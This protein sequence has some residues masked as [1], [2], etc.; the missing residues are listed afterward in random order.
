[1]T[2]KWSSCAPL[3][4]EVAPVGATSPGT[5]VYAIGDMH[6]CWALLDAIHEG[7]LFDARLRRAARRKVI[8]LGDYVSRGPDSRQVVE[9]LIEWRPPG[10]EIVALKGNHEDLLLRFLDGDFANGAQWLDHG[11]VE[12][13]AHYG[14]FLEDPAA[15]D[16][17][18][19]ADARHR[20]LATVPAAH[21]AFLR[22]LATSHRDGDY[23]FA[24]AGVLPGVPV[25][26]Q[27][28]SNLMWIR[29]RF[30]ESAADHGAIVVHG[31]SISPAP[32]IHRNRIGIDTGAY[33]S[34]ILTCAVL[35]G[36]ERAFLQTEI[37]NGPA[38]ARGASPRFVP[39]TAP[40]H[41]KTIKEET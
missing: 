8:Y 28:D 40:Q 36:T 4:G 30:L 31:H 6:G 34:G 35:D 15:R 5:V 18:T 26:D 21:R 2:L 41:T 11:G 25:D 24:H 19:L 39:T 32:D 38:E 9:R 12:A 20:L 10:F 3:P 37:G 29:S 1:M 27:C 33:R 16:D 22:G 13:L 7:I 17:A 23:L 14:V